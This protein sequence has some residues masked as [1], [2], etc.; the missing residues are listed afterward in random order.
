MPK[1]EFI[2]DRWMVTAIKDIC[3]ERG[4]T[5]TSYSDDWLLELTKGNITQRVLGYKFPLN[6]SVAAQSAEDKVTGYLILS[7]QN[8]PSVPHALVRTQSTTYHAWETY[9]WTDVVIN[10]LMGTSGLGV[11][12]FSSPDKALEWINQDPQDGWAIS[13]FV[14]IKQEI[15]LIVLDQKILLS[16]EKLSVTINGLPMFNLGLGATP[17]K[18]EAS[19]ELQELAQK[20]CKALGLRLAAVDVVELEDG[21]FTVLETNDGIMME[22]FARTSPEYKED[23]RRVY[24]AIITALFS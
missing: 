7:S 5:L 12:R 2:K 9:D 14:K 1:G 19:V 23:A 22:H 15:R 24:Q 10:P 13:P 6:N 11:K 4:I 21:S 8:I 18:I 3:L 17:K 16:Y 20:T